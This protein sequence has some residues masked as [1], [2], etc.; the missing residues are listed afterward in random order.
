MS[1]SIIPSNRRPTMQDVA[2]AAGVSLSTVYRVLNLRAKVRGDTARRIADA[3]AHL[4]FH[5]SGVL[6]R[7]VANTRPVVRLGFL[8]QKR[9]TA[10]YQGLAQAL[11]AAATPCEHAQVR[12]LI[13]YLDNLD[14]LATAQGL[15]ALQGE[16]DALGVVVPDHPATRAAVDTLRGSGMRVLSLVSELSGIGYVGLDNR[17]VG[18]TAGWLIRQLAVQPGPVAVLLGTQRFQC[19]ELCEM[20]FR[21]FWAEQGDDWE[22]LAPRLTLEDSAYAYENTLDLL[23]AQPDLAGLYIGGGGVEGVLPALREWREARAGLPPVICHDLTTVTREA[24][25]QGLV[26]AVLSHPLQVLAQRAVASLTQ[27]MTQAP[28]KWLLELQISVAESI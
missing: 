13:S 20:S 28:Q 12:V 4:G 15:L 17:K 22:L 25:R 27:P 11:S 9:G 18:R 14:P 5:A 21:S 8:L 6:E 3:A 23:N 24:L 1:D 10:F 2:E 7:R 26:Q 16:V 19:Q